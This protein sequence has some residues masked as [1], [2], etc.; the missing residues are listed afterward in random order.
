MELLTERIV[1]RKP[2]QADAEDALA[3]LQDRETMLWNPAPLVVDLE[4]A[5]A[6]CASGA[7]W[8]DGTHATWH[9][10]DRLTG[11]F[12]ANCSVFTIDREQATAKIGYRVAPWSRG[13]GVGREIVDSVT[14]WAFT[15]LGLARMQIEHA[16]A[17][18][19][20]CRVAAGAGYAWEGTLRSASVD[21][22]GERHD[23]H[24]HGRLATDPTVVLSP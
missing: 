13:R 6:W 23:D 11:R 17:N 10:T 14:R 9:A 2:D 4:S 5:R 15:E 20:S 7:D 3:M 8:S 22:Q 24:V 18:V 1:L 21:G 19:A 16:V 12:V